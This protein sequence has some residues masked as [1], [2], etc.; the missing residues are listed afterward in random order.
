MFNFLMCRL[1]ARKLI[2]TQTAHSM[3][4][5]VIPFF[6][7]FPFFIRDFVKGA[8]AGLKGNGYYIFVVFFDSFPESMSTLNLFVIWFPYTCLWCNLYHHYFLLIVPHCYN[9]TL[10]T[11][12][13]NEE[14][15][16]P[17]FTIM[18]EI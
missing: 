7:T 2:K 4:S 15:L 13:T 8:T 17:L 11:T 16:W 1:D 5:L 6:L 10:C 14:E 3:K 9:N 18:Q 12:Q